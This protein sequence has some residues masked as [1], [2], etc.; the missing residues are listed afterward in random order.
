MNKIKSILGITEMSEKN[1]NTNYTFK[2]LYALGIIFICAGHCKNGGFS[3]FY[4]FF[5]P[6]SFHL[7]LFMFAS[8]Y[9]YKT[10]K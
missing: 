3:L 1:N 10:K 4:E 6:Y 2:L 7:A 9:F 8:G 5:P